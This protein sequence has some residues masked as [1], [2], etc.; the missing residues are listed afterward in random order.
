MKKYLVVPCVLLATFVFGLLYVIMESIR[1]EQFIY[2]QSFYLFTMIVG[3][4]ML[5]CAKNN[6]MH[7][8]AGLLVFT[9]GFLVNCFNY[10]LVNHGSVGSILNYV[11]TLVLFITCVSFVHGC[12]HNKGVRPLVYVM[13]SLLIVLIAAVAI[14]ALVNQNYKWMDDMNIACFVI[15]QLSLLST[16]TIPVCMIISLNQNK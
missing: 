9:L 16:I 14:Y 2:S 4:I 11:L 7:R 15:S 13:A 3:L 1:L 6:K 5:F 8:Y 10:S 12:S